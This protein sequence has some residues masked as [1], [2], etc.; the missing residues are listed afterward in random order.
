MRS[1]ARSWVLVLL[2]GLLVCL[3]PAAAASG[4]ETPEIEK[5]FAANC[6][7]TA[8]ECGHEITATTDPFGHHFS[9][10]KEPT[11]TEAEAQG[12]VTAGG[13]VPFGVTDFKLKTTGALPFEKPTETIKHIRTDVAPGL[14]TN[15]EAVPKCNAA[16]FDKE[17][18]PGSHLYP[19]PVCASNTKV[20]AQQATAFVPTGFDVALEG[21][22]YNLEQSEGRASLFGVSLELPK[23]LTEGQLK[24]AFEHGLITKAILEGQYYA[25][26]LIEG[27]VEWGQEAKGTGAGDYH[28]YFEIEVSTS[29]PLISSR[30]TFFG[31]SGTGEF[32]RNATSCP[33]HLTTI[34]RTTDEENATVSRPYTP[35]EGIHLIEC[36]EVPFNPGFAM[37][38]ASTA[39]DSPDELTT[40]VTLP[41]NPKGIDDSHVMAASITLP[42]GMTLN[43]SAA[44]G[45]EVCTP[46]QARIHSEA[47]GTE[48]PAGSQIASVSLNVPALPNGSLTG[49]VYLGGP[50]SGPIT[51]PPYTMYIVA[52]SK[53][54]GVSV[55]LKAEVI[56]NETTGQL[57]TIVRRTP[58]QPFS[59]LT[60]HFERGDLTADRQPARMRRRHDRYGEVHAVLQS[61]QHAKNSASAHRSP[62]APRRSRSRWRRATEHEPASAAEATRPTRS[63]S[64]ATDGNQYLQ[65]VTTT[66]PAGLVGA[67]PTVTPVRRT[68]GGAGHVLGGEP[69]RHRDGDGRPGP[70]PYAFS[71]PGLH[72]RSVQRRAVRPVDRRPGGRGSVQPRHGR[73][74]L[75]DQHRPD[76]GAGDRDARPADD[77]QGRPGAP[78][79]AQR[80]R[81]QAGL[82]VQPDQ[83]R[84]RSAT[85]STLDLARSGTH[86][87]PA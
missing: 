2:T 46:A 28:D 13:R 85:E 36:G 78:A 6:K 76:H 10:T 24:E 48:C 35:P 67:I 29:L 31:T 30:L 61:V 5:F 72:D 25:H 73:D 60:L 34:L 81:Q 51:G 16:E 53:R 15:P 50:E 41:H 27:N 57:T 1:V 54:Y 20:G 49:A 47:F 42:Q 52:N 18:L 9:V 80:G 69:D 58:E 12:F 65:K 3:V 37:T 71:G 17:A 68:A 26:T 62:A 77:R 40:E 21:P 43:P 11:K 4:A 75:D 70:T 55:R 7:E 86:A 38:Q 79:V 8:P 84:A 64:T 33:G 14:A 56:P 32:I 82:P 87:S 19:A 23:P 59:N 63:T 74:A 39:S 22:V 45:L 83:L 44:A 66:L